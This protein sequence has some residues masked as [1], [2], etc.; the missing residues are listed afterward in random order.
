MAKSSATEDFVFCSLKLLPSTITVT[1]KRISNRYLRLCTQVRNKNCTIKKFGNVDFVPCSTKVNF[2]LKSY[3][4]VKETKSFK[5]QVATVK[6]LVINFQ[7][8]LKAATKVFAEQELAVL[9]LDI[10]KCFFASFYNLSMLLLTNQ[11]A[12]RPNHPAH[13]LELH[14]IKVHGIM[15]VKHTDLTAS[16]VYT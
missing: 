2:T 12:S 11:D 16:D 10:H 13:F 9:Q 7:T 15:L 8:Q 3:K 4:K 1:A 6:Q 5:T 14:V